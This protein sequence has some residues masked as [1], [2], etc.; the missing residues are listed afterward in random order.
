MEVNSIPYSVRTFQGEDRMIW[1]GPNR[2]DFD[3][4][5]VYALAMGS[6]SDEGTFNGMWVWK[7]DTIP[8]V[9]TFIW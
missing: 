1:T 3:L 6:E 7:L 5:H 2:G 9:K 4:K 8:Q